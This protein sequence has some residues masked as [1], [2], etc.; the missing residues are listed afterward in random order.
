MATG[1]I[2]TWFANAKVKGA[3]DIYKQCDTSQT[4]KNRDSYPIDRHSFSLSWMGGNIIST[5]YLELY[6][7]LLQECNK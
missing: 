6:Y 4:A 1:I 7:L 5:S 2:N 3:I